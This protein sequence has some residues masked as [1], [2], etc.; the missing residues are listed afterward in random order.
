[1]EVVTVPLR[2]TDRV[3]IVDADMA[4]V[5]LTAVCAGHRVTLTIAG[6]TWRESRPSNLQH[7][8]AL[9]SASVFDGGVKRRVSVTLHRLVMQASGGELIDHVNRDK[10]D[11]RRANLRCATAYLNAVNRQ[12]M[13]RATTPYKGIF[14]AAKGRSWSAYIGVKG[15]LVCLGSTREPVDSARLWDAGA[16]MVHG[17]HAVLNFPD[18]PPVQIK[19]KNLAKLLGRLSKLPTEAAQ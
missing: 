15:K 7:S 8:Y 2:G 12:P 16:R 5:P 11:N 19:T 14:R 10:M 4:S 3:A 9:T 13:K 1:M 6:S 17:E 18:L